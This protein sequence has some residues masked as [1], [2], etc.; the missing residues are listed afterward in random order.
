[1]SEADQVVYYSDGSFEPS[2]FEYS[3]P[4]A[5]RMAGTRFFRESDPVHIKR[6][7]A[8]RHWFRKSGCDLWGFR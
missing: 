2:K 8:Y 6:T 1:M 4:Q 7:P 3:P 5:A